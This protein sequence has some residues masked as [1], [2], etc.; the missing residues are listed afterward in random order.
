[1]QKSRRA[2]RPAFTIDWSLM[3]ATEVGAP[4]ALQEATYASRRVAKHDG[5][6]VTDV[7]ADFQGGCRDTD[8]MAFSAH[9]F[10]DA[11]PL[12]GRKRVQN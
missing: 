2:A 8:A 11:L 10:F 6:H 12:G 7:D 9:L 1:M 3:V 4:E 5:V